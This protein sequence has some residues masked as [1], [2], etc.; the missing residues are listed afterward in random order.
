MKRIFLAAAMSLLGSAAFAQD[1]ALG[2]WQTEVDDGSF[3][4]VQMSSC[5]SDIC[6]T[7]TRTFK[8]DGTEYDSPNK[9]LQIVR[10]MTPTGG[11]N[12]EGEVLRPSNNKIYIGKMQISGTQL[13]LKGCVAGG[14]ICAN[15]NWKKL[16]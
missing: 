6:G 16:Q 3:A 9:G 15:Q 7:I 13:S 12:Y 2:V 14:L 11:G 4:L 8:A 5:G 1:P 10:G